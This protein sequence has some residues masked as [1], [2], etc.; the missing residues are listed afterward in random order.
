[1]GMSRRSPLSMARLGAGVIGAGRRDGGGA[2]ALTFS[3]EPTAAKPATVAPFNKPRLLT[4]ESLARFDIVSSQQVA[5]FSTMT[6]Q[7]R[8]F[9]NSCQRC[10]QPIETCIKPPSTTLSLRDPHLV[11]S[12][13]IGAAR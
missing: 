7:C 13:E 12:R 2:C 6:R 9:A 3:G 5:I 8:V 1:M 4:V 11:P 10:G